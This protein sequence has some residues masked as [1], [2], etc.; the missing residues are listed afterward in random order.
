ML[1]CFPNS[2]VSLRPSDMVFHVRNSEPNQLF[3]IYSRMHLLGPTYSI[4]FHRTLSA[5]VA[6]SIFENRLAHRLSN[7]TPPPSQSLT[8]CKVV[9][10]WRMTKRRRSYYIALDAA[11]RTKLR[12]T[13][14]CTRS[15]R[16]SQ[17][18]PGNLLLARLSAADAHDHQLPQ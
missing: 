10:Y 16:D 14:Q 4:S 15:K 6:A 18:P 11:F 5:P 1:Q 17:R 9:Y 3:G 2:S 12:S 7:K 13:R 8:R